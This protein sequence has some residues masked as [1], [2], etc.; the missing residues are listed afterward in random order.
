MD[1]IGT[2][3]MSGLNVKKKKNILI[4]GE[5]FSSFPS[6]K[7]KFPYYL[8]SAQNILKKQTK[9]QSNYIFFENEKHKYTLPCNGSQVGKWDSNKE[10]QASGDNTPPCG[11]A[12]RLGR[13][14]TG[15]EIKSC[16][17]TEP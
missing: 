17:V 12:W 4:F 16:K 10:C 6:F 5:I 3:V 14:A 11:D 13:H 9:K 8:A 7:K 15:L 2:V 1:R